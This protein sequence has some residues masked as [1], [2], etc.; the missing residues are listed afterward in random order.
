MTKPKWLGL[1]PIL[2]SRM[3]TGAL[4]TIWTIVVAGGLYAQAAYVQRPGAI[5]DPPTAVP[6]LPPSQSG[7][8]TLVMAVHPECPCTRA[9][10][11]EL[12]R[13][14]AKLRDSLDLAFVV[15]TP[16]LPG[17][18]WLSDFRD[19]MRR[20]GFE[21]EVIVDPTGE[22]AAAMGALTSGS[23]VLLDPAGAPRFW[24]GITSG[25]GHQGDNLGSDAVL[26]IVRDGSTET[27]TTPVYG[28]PI[29]TPLSPAR[30]TD[31]TPACC[32]ETP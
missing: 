26:A 22:K 29:T 4:I 12:Q 10:L 30:P 24:G 20:L 11:G 13:L 31:A 8:Y 25:R 23:V 9:S 18:D 21:G 2:C 28:C 7:R 16:D 15:Y 17:A 5:A 27:R 14:T 6:E 3:A 32:E 19:R 1:P